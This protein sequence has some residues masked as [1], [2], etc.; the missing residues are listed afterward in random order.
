MEISGKT[1]S[2]LTLTD[3]QADKALAMYG[4]AVLLVGTAIVLAW[5]GDGWG[6]IWPFLIAAMLPV[7]YLHLTRIKTVL[8]LDKATNEITLDVK[9]RGRTEHWE[10]AFGDLET[11]VM[12][13]RGKQG[14]DSGYHRPEM[15]LKD[16]THAPMRPYHAA[17]TQSWHAVAAVKLFLGQSIAEGAPVG[18]IPPEEFD[19]YFEDEM[20][21]FYKGNPKDT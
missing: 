1:N 16:G 9:R 5:Q 6:M 3:T 2:S 17:G 20:N 11:A 14:T 10:W 15:V 12:T 7:L 19:T 18:W 21:L 4:I 8:R 13:T